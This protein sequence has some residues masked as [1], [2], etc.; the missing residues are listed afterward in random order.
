MVII[1]ASPSPI[2]ETPGAITATAPVA[3][4]SV[5][6]KLGIALDAD[7]LLFKPELAQVEHV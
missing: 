5:T 7:V 6:Q 4:D 2:I 3:A 1:E